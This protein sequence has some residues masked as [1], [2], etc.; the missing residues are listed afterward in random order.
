MKIPGGLFLRKFKLFRWHLPNWQNQAN[1]IVKRI[2]KSMVA[3]LLIKSGDSTP[4]SVFKQNKFRT[5]LE[6]IDSIRGI[7][8]A[9]NTTITTINIHTE[10]K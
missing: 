9:T 1:F 5:L 3:Q 8:I 7:A 10:Y 6:L 4:N 2:S